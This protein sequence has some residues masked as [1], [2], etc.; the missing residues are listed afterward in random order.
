VTANELREQPISIEPIGLHVPQ[1]PA[2]LNA[3]GV[4]DLVLD[5]N[6]HQVP[7][8]PEAVPAR[9]VAAHHPGRGGHREGSL[10]F[11]TAPASFAK[12]AA[13]TDT[14]RRL[15]PS[16]S[17]SLQ[18]LLLNSSAMY[19]TGTDALPSIPWVAGFIFWLLLFTVEK[20]TRG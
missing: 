16:L 12:F 10:A 5:P 17:A 11:T 13:G 19:N 3:G 18:L 4:H 14:W 15:A 1:P 6:T 7:V 20:A 2:D 9:L 8:Q